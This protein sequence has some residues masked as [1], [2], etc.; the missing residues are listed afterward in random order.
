MQSAL[1]ES[2]ISLLC[3]KGGQ[4]E[5]ACLFWLSAHVMT[6]QL[7]RSWFTLQYFIKGPFKKYVHPKATL[8]NQ[9]TSLVRVFQCSIEIFSV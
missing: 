9:P 1:D 8:L 7:S 2:K 3:G 6:S 5:L 4:F